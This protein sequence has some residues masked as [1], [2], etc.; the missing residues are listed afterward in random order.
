V[1]DHLK[2]EEVA[3]RWVAR[4]DRGFAAGEAADLESWLNEA[5]ANRIAYLRL[6]TSWEKSTQLSAL[7]PQLKARSRL[8]LIAGIAAAGAAVAA[9]LLVTVPFTVPVKVPVAQHKAAS[10]VVYATGASKRPVVLADGTRIQLNA[11]T[12]VETHITPKARTVKLDRGEV[13]FDVVHEQKRPFIVMVGD[14]RITD[15][16]TKF[17]VLRDTDSVRVVVTEGRVKVDM[18][19]PSPDAAPV[20]AGAGDV[21]IAKADGTLVTS[22][23]ASDIRDVLSWRS[24]LLTFS[25]V[26]LEDAA[27][28]FNK[29][30]RRHIVVR[31]DAKNIRIGGSFRSDNIDA[32]AF[33]VQNALGLKV[34]R[35]REKITISN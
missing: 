3:A 20:Y 6:R 29:Y 34:S 19:N 28:Q 31:G 2:I 8:G 18:A 35:S 15:L 23:S 17:S 1:V 14:R 11:M 4:E 24:E 16:G 30:N 27:A 32:F 26:T 22:H 13:Y 21:V 33:L 10:P 5:D 7:R 9:I 25:Q 12:R